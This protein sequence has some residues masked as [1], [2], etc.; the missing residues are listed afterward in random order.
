VLTLGDRDNYGFDEQALPPLVALMDAA[1]PDFRQWHHAAVTG[2][3]IDSAQAFERVEHAI[4]QAEELR[5]SESRFR[6]LGIGV[7]SGEMLAEFTWRGHL[8]PSDTPPLGTATSDAS[9]LA[10]SSP[11]AY[12]PQLNALRAKY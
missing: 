7:S 5:R 4:V 2:Y 8:K 10:A 9:L 6:S 3:F 11:N 1:A 12:Y